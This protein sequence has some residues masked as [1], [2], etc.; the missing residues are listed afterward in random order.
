MQ[1]IQTYQKRKLLIAAGGF[2]HD[3]QEQAEVELRLLTVSH[4]TAVRYAAH[5]LMPGAG[6]V[7]PRGLSSSRLPE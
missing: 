5:L 2:T 1:H 3:G 7:L 6:N 4:R